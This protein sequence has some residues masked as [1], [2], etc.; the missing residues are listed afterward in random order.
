MSYLFVYGTL[1]KGFE[2][3]LAELLGRSAEFFTGGWCKGLLY[4][5]G[6]YPVLTKTTDKDQNV[7]GDVF[8]LHNEQE[9]LTI[10]DEYE[11]VG[12]YLETGITY[13]RLKVNIE[14]VSGI[15]ISAWVYLYQG[16]LEHL[17]PIKNG[18]YLNYIKG[19]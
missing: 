9:L 14:S 11:A 19:R 10:L 7:F 18:D 8:L 12:E 1:R 3:P 4:D 16:T 17:Q 15:N 2:H 5:L 13:E 6:P